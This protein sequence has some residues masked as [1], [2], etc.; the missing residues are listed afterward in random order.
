MADFFYFSAGVASWLVAG[1]AVMAIIVMWKATTAAKRA[2]EDIKE[3]A[4]SIREFR[5]SAT[6]KGLELLE[7]AVRSSKGGGKTSE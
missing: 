7:K 5:N 2:A 3:K 6:V 1:A 4:E